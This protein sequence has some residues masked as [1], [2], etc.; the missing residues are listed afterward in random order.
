MSV[1]PQLIA[2]L[3][4]AVAHEFGAA[5]QYTLQAAQ[6]EAWGMK[7]LA[8]ELRSGVREELRH[9]EIFL[10]RLLAAGVPPRVGQVGV[11]RVGASHAEL[12]QL[13]MATESD[14][15]RLYEAGRRFCESIGDTDNA[16]VFAR[17]YDDERAHHSELERQLR[18][19]AASRLSQQG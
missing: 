13:G 16:A 7:Q 6:A 11:A 8:D 18:A 1:H 19:T 5:Q 12:L 9:A 4:R 3:Q 15:L 17:I 10:S 14:A 2:Y